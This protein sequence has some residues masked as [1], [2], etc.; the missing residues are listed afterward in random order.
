MDEVSPGDG[1]RYQYLDSV[2]TTMDRN[3]SFAEASDWVATLGAHTREFISS[4]DMQS[5]N[6]TTP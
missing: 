6:G 5:V 3:P 4:M 2:L 1:L